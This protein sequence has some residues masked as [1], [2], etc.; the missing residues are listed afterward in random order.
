MRVSVS[1]DPGTVTMGYCVWDMKRWER[2]KPSP[3]VAAGK[4]DLNRSF[5]TSGQTLRNHIS[6][7]RELLKRLD[8]A[9]D[10]YRVERIYCEEM[11]GF[12]GVRADAARADVLHVAFATGAI[13][14]YAETI[15]AAFHSV[16]VNK[17]KGQLKKEMV[18]RRILKRFD[19]TERDD[20]DATTFGGLLSYPIS[21]DWDAFGIG[22]FAQ[23]KF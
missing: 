9:L 14:H 13:F 11:Q 1:I 10:G 12:D 23:G 22:L 21:H 16:P 6:G 7:V 3:P 15:G 4:Y 18:Y 20:E 8:S 17:W 19:L 5:T 2:S